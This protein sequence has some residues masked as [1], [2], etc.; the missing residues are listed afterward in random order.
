MRSVRDALRLLSL[1]LAFASA[2]LAAE[3][4]AAVMQ[5]G[6]SIFVEKCSM[7]HL[8]NGAGIPSV[9]PP[10]AQSDWLMADRA[11]AVRV[12]AQGL[13]EKITVNGIVYN[14]IMPAQILDDA[15]V[16]DVLTYITNSWGNQAAPFT[17]E[18]VR[19]ARARTRFNTYEALVKASTYSPL[20]TPPAGLKVR[21]VAQ[22]PELSTRIAKG[23]NSKD[24]FALAQNGGIYRIDLEH[25][26][27]VSRI[28]PA[29]D[30]LDSTKG[31]I[32]ALGM[33]QDDENRLLVVINQRN[34]RTEPYVTNDVTIYRTT[35]M[36]DGVPA[37]FKPW[38]VTTY[39][40]GIGYYDHGVNKIAFGP[41]GMLYLASG[42][43]TDGGEKGT[44]P[45]FS[46]EGEVDLSAAIWR[47]DP[48]AENPKAV[49]IVHGLRNAFGFDW[50][51]QGRMFSV[52]NGPDANM[53]EEMDEI[54]PGRHYGFPYQY[55]D[56]P[57]T[58]G[59]PYPHTPPAPAGLTFTHPV[60]NFGPAAGGSADKPLST[61]DPHSSPA[62]MIWCGDEF[63]EPLRNRFLVARY[64]NMLGGDY[65]PVD[66]GFDVVSVQLKKN[67]ADG[68][69]HAKTE[70][71]LAPLGRPIDIIKL[72]GGRALI[73]EYTRPTDYRSQLPQMGG[74][75]IEISASDKP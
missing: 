67:E 65:A 19:V 72:E 23:R 3:P 57:A 49:A 73:L 54:I 37:T 41:D 68:R 26:G 63:P 59:S 4:D 14:N 69:W 5:R 46:Q 42:S 6:Q 64:G 29:G 32:Q 71:I 13:G 70:T 53:P 24:A 1:P 2:A 18:E 34:D 12:L 36:K 44:N 31:K 48:K 75:I 52:T 10:L 62:G 50:D 60:L 16:S 61:F 8:M 28:I 27:A 15:A 22:L 66:V 74:R 9:Y 30:Y 20:P 7:C 56:L 33:T 40:Y 35:E 43:R 55:G 25:G 47:I 17:A 38:I 39:P 11:R 51:N 21:E 45:R 58:A